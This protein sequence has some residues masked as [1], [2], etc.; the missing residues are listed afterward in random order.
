MVRLRI[1]LAFGAVALSLLAM[2][3]SVR[4]ASPAEMR[5]DAPADTQV[6]GKPFTARVSIT[7]AATTWAGYNDQVIYDPKV[8]RVNSVKAGGIA[9]CDPASTWGSP[10]TAPTIQAAC[11]FQAT[12]VT[13]VTE[14]IEFECLKDGSSA[15]HLVTTTED[16][17]G[18]TGL[19]DNNAVPIPT[20]LV[21]SSVTCGAGGPIETIAVPTNPAPP[22][23]IPAD[24][25]TPAPGG[26]TPG[27]ASSAAAGGTPGAGATG[28][29]AGGTAASGTATGPG[30]SAS[31]GPAATRAA[32]TSSASK[33]STAQNA[34]QTSSDSGMPAWLI[35]VIVVVV[36]G[37]AGGAGWLVLR[38]RKGASGG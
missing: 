38:R 2:T 26:G 31:A 5:V 21:D 17:I 37:A 14:I 36:L 34:T 9:N 27:A 23:S 6:V 33:T 1:P 16:N 32:A 20:D 22:T 30:A 24:G 7:R 18:G 12:Q 11:V 25:S 3:I 15:L 19:F 35:A 28:G 4:A 29:A 10:Q 13:G 8:L